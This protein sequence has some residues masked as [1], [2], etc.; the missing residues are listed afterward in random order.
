MGKNKDITYSRFQAYV[1]NKDASVNHIID[2]YLIKTQSMFVYENLPET[3]PQ[4]ELEHLLQVGGNCFVTK[5]GE[6]LYAL[7][8]NPGGEPDAYN[9]PTKYIV[10][11]PAL[12]LTKEYTIGED[13]VL[14]KNDYSMTG[15]LP[16]LGKYAVLLTDSTISLNTVAVLSRITLLLSA[17][18]D[19][20][21]QSADLFI[22]KILDGDFSVIGENA[23]LKGVN[24]QTP[25]SGNS[26]QL[27]QLI[28]LVQ[29]YKANLLNELGL[30]ANYN[31]K[32]ERLNQGEVGMNVDALLPFVDNMLTERKK[33]VDAINEMYGTEITVELSSSW[34][35]THDENIHDEPA[36]PEVK[37]D[38]E[39]PAEIEETEETIETQESSEDK[40]EP[41]KDEKDE[42]Q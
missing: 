5:V 24:L 1:K 42:I 12:K 31:M 30:N 4:D 16:L 34:K 33:A 29:Y 35:T 40:E 11:N 19:K 22:K 37:E 3:I 21:K 7:A 36:T 25:P 23:F 41:E 10:A 26:L 6:D 15:L 14:M 32:R 20:T 18:D 9:R 17:S 27:T 39:Q 13:G 28:E 8:G 2:N 38:E